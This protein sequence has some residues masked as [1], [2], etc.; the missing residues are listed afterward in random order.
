[1][2][3]GVCGGTEDAKTLESCSRQQI[4]F[5][6]TCEKV[7]PCIFCVWRHHF[8]ALPEN[9]FRQLRS[10]L[11][12]ELAQNPPDIAGSSGS[13]DATVRQNR[14]W[15]TEGNQPSARSLRILNETP[16]WPSVN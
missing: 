2:I 6:V 8:C 13:S 10:T 1:M 16:L 14:Q 5:R 3:T 12:L 4:R 15:K 7:T 9:G 11:Q